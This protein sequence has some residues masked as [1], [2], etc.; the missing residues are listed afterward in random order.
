MIMTACDCTTAHTPIVSPLT[1][2]EL[3]AA[4]DL[5]SAGNDAWCDVRDA[6]EHSGARRAMVAC[7]AIMEDGESF[8]HAHRRA[9]ERAYPARIGT[10][11]LVHYGARTY[12]DESFS[13]HITALTS[14]Q[15]H[16][17][18]RA[19]FVIHAA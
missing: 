7:H 2:Q 13:A 12:R 5:L 19:A 6:M 18:M 4:F 3:L 17:D 16:G 15:L 8:P 14:F 1:P 11:S 10:S 9:Y